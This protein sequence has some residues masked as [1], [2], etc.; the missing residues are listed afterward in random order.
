M[1]DAPRAATAKEVSALIASAGYDEVGALLDRYG[2]D[3]RRQV[4]HAVA[5]A[6]RRHE[7]ERA[8]R[9]RVLAMY[10]LQR[11]L[12]GDGVVVGVDE[13]GRGAV[14]G[15]LTV[16]AVVLPA[17]PVVWGLNDSKQLTSERREQLAA[18]IADVALAIGMAHI[19]PASIDAVG[20]ACALRMGMS[21]AIADTGVDPDCVLIDGNPVHVHPR[22]HTLVKGDARVA[23]I[24]AASIVAK[25]TRDHLMV[26]LDEE[27]PGYHLAECKGYG[28]PDHIA[29]IRQRGLS[30]I[31][32]ASF[33]A[34]FMETPPLF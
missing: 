2:D 23:C 27:Y 3:P 7:R 25:V 6:R 34:N 12:G 22:E 13:V 1:T 31:H 20:M 9:E 16:G 17:E 30:P 24:A 14:A 5:T 11:E 29:A 18:R 15:P 8:E 21:Q 19:E 10:A 26:G 4:Q 32:R 28:S 33:C